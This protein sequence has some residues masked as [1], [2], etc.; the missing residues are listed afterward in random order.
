[1]A[2][3]FTS[4]YKCFRVNESFPLTH[5]LQRKERESLYTTTTCRKHP[6]TTTAL[7]KHLASI[8]YSS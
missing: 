3:L 7:I 5:I 6:I 1:M 4:A 8:H 2:D